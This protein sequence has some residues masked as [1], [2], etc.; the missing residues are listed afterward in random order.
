LHFGGRD[1]ST[2]IYAIQQIETLRAKDESVQRDIN[3]ISSLFSQ[4]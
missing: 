1:H 4:Q 2:V 3:Y